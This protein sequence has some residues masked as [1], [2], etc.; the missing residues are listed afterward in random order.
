MTDKVKAGQIYLA[1]LDQDT[2][3]VIAITNVKDGIIS[4]INQAGVTDS[5][6]EYLLPEQDWRLL[7]EYPTWN[8]AV[9]SKEFGE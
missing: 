2:Y 4:T 7:A 8:Q 1:I 5:F 9:N 6:H 3:M